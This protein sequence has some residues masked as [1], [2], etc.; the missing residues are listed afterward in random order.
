MKQEKIKLK[1]NKKI[2]VLLVYKISL[3]NHYLLLLVIIYNYIF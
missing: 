1:K 3:F 2:R